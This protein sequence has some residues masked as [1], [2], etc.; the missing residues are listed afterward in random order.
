MIHELRI[1]LI[2]KYLQA[3]F[4]LFFQLRYPFPFSNHIPLMLNIYSPLTDWSSFKIK[5]TILT[6]STIPIKTRCVIQVILA[7]FFI[8][9]MLLFES[10]LILEIMFFMSTNKNIIE[11]ITKNCS[12]TIINQFV[13]FLNDKKHFYVGLKPRF[14]AEN[15]VIKM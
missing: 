8:S 3:F 6:A 1:Y 13:N 14:F 5:P 11:T 15:H 12:Q 7:G 9:K 4:A 10:I 2:Q